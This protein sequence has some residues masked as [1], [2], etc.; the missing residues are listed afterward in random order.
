KVPRCDRRPEDWPAWR[1]RFL[2]E[3]RAAAA[4]RHPHVCPIHDVGEHDGVPFVVLER[5]DGHSLAEELGRR[6]RYDNPVEAVR[7]VRQVADALAAVHA[8]GVVHRDLKPGNVLLDGARRAVL[9]DFGLARP[10]NDAERLTAD[11]T[12]LGTPAYMAPEQAAGQ[13]D[14][15]GPWTDVYSLGVV[16]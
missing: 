3:A 7:L 2:R 9:T 8:H 14:R 15:V 5:V 12:L 4:V 6:G 1:Q 10:E 13:S 11:G 16:L